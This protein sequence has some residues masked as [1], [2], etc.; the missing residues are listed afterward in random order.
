MKNKIIREG[1]VYG[2][3]GSINK[4]SSLLLL[5]LYTRLLTPDDY[6]L[7]E[8]MLTISAALFL[9]LHLQLSSGILRFY[10][11]S[12]SQ[13]TLSSLLGTTMTLTLI[14][15]GAALLIALLFST[16]FQAAFGISPDILIAIVAGLLPS[17]VMQIVL[18]VLRLEYR[19]KDYLLYSGGQFLA[20]AVLGALSAIFL[21]NKVVGI[22]WAANISFFIVAV[23]CLVYVHRLA[24]L[25]LTLSSARELLFYSAP[26][27]PSLAGNWVQ[28][29]A[30][31]FFIAASLGLTS[32]GIYSVA[33]RLATSYEL[34]NNSFK[35]TWSPYAM[36]RI[37]ENDTEKLFVRD[38]NL[39]IFTSFASVV[40]ISAAAIP[41]MTFIVPESFYLGRLFIG[42]L[43]ISNAVSGITNIVEIG[44]LWEKQTYKNSIGAVASAVITIVII[45]LTIDRWGLIVVPVATLAGS[46]AKV[47]LIYWSAQRTRFIPYTNSMIIAI[48]INL[49]FASYAYL[50]LSYILPNF[51]LAT[52]ALIF[53]GSILILIAW[54]LTLRHE[55]KNY[56][57]RLLIQ[58][59]PFL[60][61]SSEENAR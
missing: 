41:L 54:F 30:S 53:G 13:G 6:G 55:D 22:L 49:L 11:D 20:Y 1:L 21:T 37:E 57:R 60:A 32:V 40:L 8:L 19:P 51:W 12:K 14:L 39:Y 59:L 46:V 23:P 33:S 24:P 35:L 31:R 34:L 17:M 29:S 27:M 56:L 7:L 52:A 10:Y 50:A 36:N 45:W 38:L 26:I 61:E 15:N 25:K 3:A 5:P 44:N 4:F 2:L 18:V 9:V 16:R 42:F 28:R 43:I 48:G 58:A 47:L